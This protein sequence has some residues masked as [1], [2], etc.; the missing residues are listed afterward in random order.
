MKKLFT[1][2]ML[3]IISLVSFAQTVPSLQAV[4]EQGA[5][6][7]RTIQFS[8][9]IVLSSLFAGI[10]MKTNNSNRWLIR[11]QA[12][13]L[14]NNAGSDLAIHSYNDA[15]VWIR[16]NLLIE[17]GSGKM[18]VE[19]DLSLPSTQKILVGGVPVINLNSNGNDIYGN[20]RVLANSSPV[21]PDG[22]YI[23]Y[24]SPGG[25]LADVRFY[26]DGITERMVIKAAN[27]N[28]GIGTSDPKA[29]LAVNGDILAKK[30][31][32]TTNN[33]PDY[34]FSEHYPLPSLQQVETFIQNNK[35]LPGIPSAT[36]IEKNGQDVGELNKQLLEK[37]EQLTLYVIDQHKK[38]EALE[39]EMKEMKRAAK[40]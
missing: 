27:G 19:G 29:K 1:L 16:Q 23:N 36:E 30:I 5:S 15:G 33:W 12:P 3:C 32:V 8:N 7:D 13:E 10:E 21:Y 17:R 2:T 4:T 18:H 24:G 9:G 37:I 25:S 38:I 22:M 26:A 14:G 31:K 40:K 11:H 6:T 28:V 20:F 34:V 39:K 35:H